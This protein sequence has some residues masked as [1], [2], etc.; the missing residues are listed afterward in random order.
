MTPDDAPGAPSA[1]HRYIPT[2]TERVDSAPP[3]PVQPVQPDATAP[4]AP[5]PAAPAPMAAVTP[6]QVLA[7]LAPDLDQRISAAMAQ[8]VHEQMQGLGA[9]VRR[10][11]AAVVQDAVDTALRQ[12]G[13]GPMSG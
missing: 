10:S 12:A 7:L 3:A 9:R 1:P 13:K 8:A 2:L 4:A 5:A 11:V 6:E